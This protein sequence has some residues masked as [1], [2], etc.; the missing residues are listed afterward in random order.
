MERRGFLLQRAAA[1][2]TCVEGASPCACLVRGVAFVLCVERVAFGA[3]GKPRRIA[4]RKVWRLPLSISVKGSLDVYLSEPQSTECS[5]MWG[6]P[7]ESLTGVRNAMP[8]T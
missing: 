7:V 2:G 4:L 6:T 5:R 3:L 8:N 1:K